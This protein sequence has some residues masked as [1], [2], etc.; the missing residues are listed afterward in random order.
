MDSTVTQHLTQLDADRPP[1][2][3]RHNR[4]LVPVLALAGV[5]AVAVGTTAITT[6]GN[7]SAR[8]PN[9]PVS[10]SAPSS[11]SA[12]STSAP[13]TTAP[14]SRP[15][16]AA[17]ASPI[18]AS[19]PVPALLRNGA[20][21]GRAQIPWKQVGPGW[22]LARTDGA[23][24]ALYLINPIG[25]RY[26]ITD[27]LPDAQDRIAEWSPDGKRAMLSREK[28]AAQIITELDL[29][30]GRMSHTV[31]IGERR[32]F[33]YTRPQGSAIL[34]IRSAGASPTLERL[35][36]DGS[37]Q[38]TYPRTLPG[39]GEIGFPVLY[40][41]DGTELLVGGEHGMA[42]LGN[43]GHLIRLLPAPASARGCWPARWWNSS[44]VLE[45]CNFDASPR[46][47]VLLQPVA[48]GQPEKLAG[49]STTYPL[50]FTNAWRYSHGTLLSEGTGCGPGRL[51]VLRDGVIRRLPLPAG[52]PDSPP[53]I[54]V[55][56][57]LLTVQR[58]GGCPVGNKESAISLNLVTGATLTLFQGI[59]YPWQQP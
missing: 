39:F 33:G 9:A 16:A 31:N 28:G 4:W 12:L 58:L 52:V 24:H 23:D 53:L 30:T 51:D 7:S 11:T 35:A 3:P 1:A 22:F 47:A 8:K 42:L 19:H 55:N 25:G 20:Q 15:S 59:P 57:D 40:N 17:P 27:Q 43:N 56:G 2:R 36:T 54:G 45:T 50:G 34:V 46:Y 13:R 29:A 44:T 6:T 49:A 48:G 32:F 18:G 14:A 5:T 37:H 41:A 21:Q 26:L 10:T 38:L